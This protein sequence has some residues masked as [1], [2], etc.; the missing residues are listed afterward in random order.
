MS[1]SKSLAGRKRD[2]KIWDFFKYKEDKN[3]SVCLAQI[4]DGT[5]C[6]FHLAGKNPTNLKVSDMGM[7]IYRNG[8]QVRN[9]TATDVD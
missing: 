5:A 6:G 9:G 7:T 3:K 4:S 2:N 1:L 8:P